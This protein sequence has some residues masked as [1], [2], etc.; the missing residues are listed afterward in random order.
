MLTARDTDQPEE[1]KNNQKD[2][3]NDHRET[4]NETQ[5]NCKDTNITKNNMLNNYMKT[6]INQRDTNQLQKDINNRKDMLN[7]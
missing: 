7:Y 6:Q 2:T 5:I 1:H 4:Q 3:L